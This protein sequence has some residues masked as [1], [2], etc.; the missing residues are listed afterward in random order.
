MQRS[1]KSWRSPGAGSIPFAAARAKPARCLVDEPDRLRHVVEDGLGRGVVTSTGDV[2]A[3]R[4]TPRRSRAASTCATPS[5]ARRSTTRRRARACRARAV[6]ASATAR[7]RSRARTR[8]EGCRPRSCPTTSPASTI[9]GF[10]P[11]ASTAFDGP[12]VVAEPVHDDEI[13]IAERGEVGGRRLVVVG[14]DR[15]AADDRRDLAAGAGEVA[16]DVAPLADRHDD[17]HRLDRAVALRPQPCPRSSPQAASR[18]ASVA[19]AAVATAAHARRF[20]NTNENHTQLCA[21]AHPGAPGRPPYGGAVTSTD[22]RHGLTSAEVADRVA[23][24]LRNDVP[25]APTRTVAEIVKANVFTRF[26][27]LVGGAARRHP[28]RRARSTTP[29]SAGSS[30]PTRSSASSRSSAAKRTLDRLA[31][32]NAPHARVV[33]DG[34][35]VE[36]AR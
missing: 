5:P 18:T 10:E 8:G 34:E 19:T 13:G 28:D 6:I 17:P 20:E 3:E 30:S 16:D 31:V 22:V 1:S 36:P 12:R 14:I 25:D 7:R 26:N 9:A 23:R 27:F 15:G 2:G 29:S 4:R 21:E 11:A 32:V 24:G 35:V 33:R